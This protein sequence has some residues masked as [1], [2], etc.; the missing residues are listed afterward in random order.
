M[1]HATGASGMII[2]A[3]PI[4]SIGVGCC[5]LRRG[6]HRHQLQT[7]RRGSLLGSCASLDLVRRSRPSSLSAVEASHPTTLL[8]FPPLTGPFCWV[9]KRSP[10]KTTSRPTSSCPPAGTRGS[11]LDPG[12]MADSEPWKRSGTTSRISCELAAPGLVIPGPDRGK[13]PASGACRIRRSGGSSRRRAQQYRVRDSHRGG[14][15]IW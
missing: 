6:A 12:T 13:V 4:R 2:R 8:S 15:R 10:C 11:S 5:C 7:P 14:P 1:D 9:A 3:L